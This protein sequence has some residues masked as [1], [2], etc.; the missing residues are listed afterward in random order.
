MNLENAR[1]LVNTERKL[2]LLEERIRL[3]QSRPATAENAESLNSL[4]QMANQLREEI[5]RYR[6]RDKRRAS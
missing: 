1:Q 6:A 5:V 4:T 2:A 3:A